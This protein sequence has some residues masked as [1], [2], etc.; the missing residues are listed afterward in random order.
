MWRTIGH[1]KAIDILD[2]SLRDDRLAHGYL[3][4][5]PPNI[6]KTTLALELAQ[7]VNCLEVSKPCSQCVQCR[8][9]AE[10]KHTDVQIISRDQQPS[11]GGEKARA[12]IGIDQVREMQR[13]AS[14]KPFEGRCRVFI[15]DEA[16]RMSDEAANCLLKTLE[17]PP[18]Q[19]LLV[20]ITDREPEAL[21]QTIVS[22]CRVIELQPL[23]TSVVAKQLTERWE[24]EQA[25]A[26]E[27]AHISRGRIGWAVNALTD[28]NFLA[29]RQERLERMINALT[30]GLEER[31]AYAA[32]M[33]SQFS[34]DREMV[35]V[36]LELWLSL[37]RDVLVIK[38]GARDVVTNVSVQSTLEI[39]A[40]AVSST[41]IV[42]GAKAVDQTWEYLG[43]NANPRLALEGLMLKLPFIKGGQIAYS[44]KGDVARVS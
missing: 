3:L 15:F 25:K 1:D 11:Q 39:V 16:D 33:A 10:G 17:E 31:F 23:P 37:L 13:I 14:L 41:D 35:K 43:Q 20:L 22:R 7:A 21:L 26:E 40:S 8:R 9:V 18:S 6:G 38:E 42:C 27:L 34:R 44:R 2:R 4:L 28:P 29:P 36:E 5:G 12:E 30:G 32:E 19:V 24:A